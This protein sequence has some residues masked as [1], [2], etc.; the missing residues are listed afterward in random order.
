[1]YV[2]CHI[3]SN[4]GNDSEGIVG[5]TIDAFQETFM[6]KHLVLTFTGP[7]KIGIVDRI[8]EIIFK[9]GGNIEA[10][11]MA[12]LGGE[13]AVLVLL[14][15]DDEKRPSLVDAFKDLIDQGYQVLTRETESGGTNKFS[16][17]LPYKLSL[18]GADHEGIIHQIA[19]YLAEKKVHVETMDTG[20]VQAPMSGTPL[21]FMTATLLVPPGLIYSELA[22]TLDKICD[23]LMVTS[24]LSA[25]SG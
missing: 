23:E 10:S 16:G 7:D 15:V 2:C 14:S 5:D 22:R 25:F 9:H 24:E 11:K 12:R 21:F 6:R 17:W 19:H 20:I 1:L 8:S 3:V 4:S 13:F 18:R